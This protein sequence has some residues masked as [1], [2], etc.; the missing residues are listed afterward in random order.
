MI[1][2]YNIVNFYYVVD[3]ENE[4]SIIDDE[5]LLVFKDYVDAQYAAQA[6]NEFLNEK[7]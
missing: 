2:V 4:E 7:V 6:W 5:Q 1:K 3:F